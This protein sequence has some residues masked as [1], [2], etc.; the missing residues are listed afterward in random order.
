MY[1]PP[2]QEQPTKQDKVQDILDILATKGDK[3]TIDMY[4]RFGINAKNALG[5]RMPQIRSI[6]KT[7]LNSTEFADSLWNT[8]I[9]EARL[10]ATIIANPASHDESMMDRWIADVHSWDLCDQ[11]CINLFCRSPH[12][13][14]KRY[15]WVRR[16][17]EFVKRAGFSLSATLAVHDK[18]AP[19]DNFQSALM[20]IA[21]YGI[22]SRK[23]VR[24]AANWSLRQ[25]GK[26][27]LSL[28]TSALELA[29]DLLE[30]GS[31]DAEWIAKDALRELSS[32]KIHDRILSNH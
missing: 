10:L 1:L 17:E 18:T 26:R 6:A 23:L 21:D 19:D 20:D 11:C 8:G 3:K 31:R 9:H 12:A 16:N 24:K 14:S 13:W 15:D 29:N 32:H 4:R 30:Q 7:M 2:S 28:Y 25:I 22:D 27:N 5:V